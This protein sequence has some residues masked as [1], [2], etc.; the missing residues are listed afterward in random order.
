M[1]SARVVDAAEAVNSLL[2]LDASD[3]QSVLEMIQ[4]YFTSPLD[5]SSEDSD[6]NNES[7]DELEEG[8]ITLKFT[9]MCIN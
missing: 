8:I 6:S 4:D 1:A 7:D 9:S 3:Q 2:H 5:D